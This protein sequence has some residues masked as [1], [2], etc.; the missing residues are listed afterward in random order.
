MVVVKGATAMAQSKQLTVFCRG[1]KLEVN[2][3]VHGCGKVKTQEQ[4]EALELTDD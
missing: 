2:C 3:G 1:K 4:L